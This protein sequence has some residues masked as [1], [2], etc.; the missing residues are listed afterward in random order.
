MGVVSTLK[1]DVHRYVELK[2]SR[3]MSHP[4]V[5]APEELFPEELKIEGLAANI[6]V[7]MSG[8]SE[9]DDLEQWPRVH[10]LFANP[11]SDQS[12]SLL[13]PATIGTTV[14]LYTGNQDIQHIQG[15]SQQHLEYEVHQTRNTGYDHTPTRQTPE[16]GHTRQPFERGTSRQ[17]FDR[18]QSRQRTPNQ[19]TSTQR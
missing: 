8:F 1:T 12:M 2:T 10:K 16:R 19:S 9:D 18:G 7:T 11:Y 17:G 6:Y 14:S 15:Y 13:A 3:A 5:D 4:Y